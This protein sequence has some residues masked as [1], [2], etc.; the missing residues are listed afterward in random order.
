M[1][2]TALARSDKSWFAE[3]WRTIDHGIITGAMALLAFG[4]LL[5][6]AAGPEAAADEGFGPLHYVKRHA[7]FMVGAVVVLF[8]TSMLSE[9]WAR[10]F[11]FLVFLGS[12]AMLAVIFFIGHTAGGAQRWIRVAG[13]SI[14]PS[15]FIK[16]ALVVIA[17]WLLAQ[18]QQY[19]GVPWG[20]ITFALF[21]PTVGLFLLQPDVGQSVLL[22]SAFVVAFFVSGL[23]LSWAL[24]F[25]GGSLATGVSLFLLFPHVQQRILAFVGMGTEGST[26]QLERAHEA[27]ANGGLLGVGPGE[28][29]VK[30][31]LPDPHT[32]FIYSVAGEE[33]G[34]IACLGLIII[35][36]FICLRGILGASRRADPYLRAAGTGLFFLFGFQA[37]INIGV[38]VGLLPTK[39]MTL[40]FISYGGSSM[41]GTALTL[42]LGLALT[43]KRAEYHPGIS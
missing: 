30:A 10:R 34:F 16:P 36:A 12:F 40:P 5:S 9:A 20:L 24:M 7:L 8:G 14:Q 32:D 42:G 2:M 37:F 4:M 41:L 25:L 13:F 28:G 39:G 21:A 38:N 22:T 26:F 35:Y 1:S 17:A 19:K 6:L 23:P 43:R 31:K 3:W 15:E 33:L 18:R 11:C 27:I 29:Y